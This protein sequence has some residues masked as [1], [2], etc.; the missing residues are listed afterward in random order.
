MATSQMTRNLL[1]ASS[2]TTHMVRLVYQYGLHQ[3]ISRKLAFRLVFPKSLGTASGLP[4][5]PLVDK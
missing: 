4:S 3:L 1:F 5:P 2:R